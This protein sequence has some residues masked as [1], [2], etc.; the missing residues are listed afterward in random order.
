MYTQAW[1]SSYATNRGQRRGQ[2]LYEI[3]NSY[4]ASNSTNSGD[5]SCPSD[6]SYLS[7]NGAAFCSAYISYNPPVS[8]A[9]ATVTPAVSVLTST[10]TDTSITTV[11]S[12]STSNVV[13]TLTLLQ[14]ALQ[15]PASISTWSPSRISKACLAVA[16]GKTSTTATATA[17]T[18]FSTVLTTQTSTNTVTIPTTTTIVSTSTVNAQ[19]TNLVRD[20]GF[21]V[22]TGAWEFGTFIDGSGSGTGA[23]VRN[24]F[25]AHSGEAWA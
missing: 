1:D 22:S 21:E 15:S 6:V 9:T 25:A 5:V 20:P 14:R 23:I 11:Y 19:P 12:T 10:E 3:T 7:A 2:N 18:P 4:S 13:M 17:A 16:T 8:T 24:P